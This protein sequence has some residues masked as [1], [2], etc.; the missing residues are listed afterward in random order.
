MSA[1]LRTR[2]E[3]LRTTALGGAVSWTVPT[4][5]ARTWQAMGAEAEGSAVQSVTGKDGPVLVVLQLAGGNDGLNTVIPVNNDAYRK[6][7]RQL[8]IPASDVLRLNDDL[9]WHPALKG[10]R[11]LHEEG[12][13]TVIQGVGYPNPNRSHFRSM[14]IWQTASDAARF[15]QQGWLGRYFDHACAGADPAVGVS[16]GRQMPQA[17]TARTPTGIAVEAQ[18]R[19]PGRGGAV[20]GAGKGREPG[21]GEVGMG[22]GEG[23]G[24][25][26]YADEGRMEGAS[27]DGL[28][29]RSTATAGVLDYLDRTA[30]DAQVSSAKVKEI[31]ARVRSAVEY[32]ST[33]LGQS[34]RLVAQLIG[35]GLP[36]RVYYVSHGGFDTHT[37]QGPTHA[38]LLGEFGDGVRAFAD[39]LKAQGHWSR[40]MVMTFSEFGRRVAA[41]ASGGTD[42]GAAGPMFLMGSRLRAPLLGR[43]PDLAPGRLVNGDLAFGVDFRSVYA[44]VLEQWLKVPSGKI[45]GRR[46]EASP[47]V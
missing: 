7:R 46:F 11:S 1:M 15:E 24:D 26:G 39:D 32:P 14:E 22:M 5:L 25:G 38:R 34:L 10:L 2:R 35:G 18:G 3:F 9:G 13:A 17:F 47:V 29:G 23:A 21:M 42:H 43:H 31:T 28:S 6:A 30:L 12:Q 44:G 40:V 41:N 4:F 37:N 36:A 33:R 27:I 20:A 19:T 8:A 45:L 16:V